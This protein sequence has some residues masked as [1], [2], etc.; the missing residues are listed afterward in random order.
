[1]SL[2]QHLELL[3]LAYLMVLSCVLF[4]NLVGKLLGHCLIQSTS[5]QVQQVLSKNVGIRV[6]ADSL[7]DHVFEQA[8]LKTL[9]TQIIF[10]CIGDFARLLGG[11]LLKPILIITHRPSQLLY[12]EKFWSGCPPCFSC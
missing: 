4:S 9:N 1:M 8:F 5:G 10:H 3:P 6:T 7:Q 2:F 12:P 11:V